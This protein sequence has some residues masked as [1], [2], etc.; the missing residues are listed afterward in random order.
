MSKKH[1]VVLDII[2]LTPELLKDPSLTPN[3]QKLLKE[4]QHSL[5]KPVF[6]AV[7]GTMQATYITGK[8]PSE[9]GIISNGIPDKDYQEITMWNQTM[10]PIQGEKLWEKVKKQDPTA[11][12]AILFWQF[13]KLTTAD[14][15]VTPAPVH[16]DNK[17]LMWCDSKPRDLY[18]R[19][20]EKYGEFD[21]KT[22]WGPLSSIQSSEWIANAALDV[23]EE[24]RPRL[25]L[26][27]LPNL[28]YSNQRSGPNSDESKQAMKEL[29]TLIGHFIAKLEERGLRDDT[30]LVILS[31]YT[32]KSVT[33]PIYIN[34]MLNEQ[35]YIAVKSV[36][37]MDFL[38]IEMSRAYALADHQLAHVY[39]N[40]EKDIPQ[41][42][43]LLKHTPGIKEVWEESEKQLNHIDHERAGDLIAIAE[44]DSW[45][46]YYWWMEDKRAPEFAYNVDI[47][48][49]PGYDPMELFVDPKT[50]K[51]PF[52]AERI[53]GSHGLPPKNKDD[54][55]SLIVTGDDINLPEQME[56]TDVHNLL[57]QL[58]SGSEGGMK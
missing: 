30:R 48:R 47:H 6:P 7:T 46:A 53:K 4:S 31:E 26:V 42:K 28:D 34:R 39:I 49:K 17:T 8:P 38:D 25:S 24:F 5:V 50:F 20:R 33:R 44:H 43:K 27:Y 14:Y 45:F 18:A 35:G 16:L 23:L 12:T 37:N 41:V 1:V 57:L 29:D 58:V 32:F 55:V 10:I 9:H 3:L 19:L 22:F 40:E 56:A 13:S 36:E 11:E 2:S 15:V 54:Y 51:I 52:D 21:L